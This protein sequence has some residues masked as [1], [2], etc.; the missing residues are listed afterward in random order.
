METQII[1][2]IVDFNFALGVE[3]YAKEYNVK[4][5]EKHGISESHVEL[6]LEGDILDLKTLNEIAKTY[7]PSVNKPLK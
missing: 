2:A 6:E 5:L 3:K 1:K 7:K 4:I